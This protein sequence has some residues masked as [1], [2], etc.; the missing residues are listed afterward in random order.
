MI[1]MHLC[2]Q[3]GIVPGFLVHDSHL[4][5]GIDGRHVI[6]ALYVGAHTASKLGFQHFVANE[7]DAFE[8]TETGFEL[9]EYVL[10]VMLTDATE[11]GGLFGMRFD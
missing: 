8:E 4:L 2:H 5:D 7:N 6:C 3:R 9:G 1:L 11:D 10:P